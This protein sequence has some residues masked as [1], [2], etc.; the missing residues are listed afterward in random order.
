MIDQKEFYGGKGSYSYVITALGARAAL[1]IDPTPD[2]M[3]E[4]VVELERLGRDCTYTLETGS[5]PGA[6]WAAREI[7]RCWAGRSIVP[8]DF[9]DDSLLLRVGH[10]DVVNLGGIKIDVIGRIGRTNA[11]ISYRIADRVFIGDRRVHEEPE[12]LALGPEKRAY[13]SRCARGENTQLLG[14][15]HD[16]LDLHGRDWGIFRGAAQE[17][18]SGVVQAV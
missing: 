13:R 11:A 3:D 6:R 10:G 12:L 2:L 5:V 8:C 1:L 14:R 16:V 15:S 17:E 18:N 9:V 7:G 4:Y